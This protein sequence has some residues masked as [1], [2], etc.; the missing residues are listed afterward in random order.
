MKDAKMTIRLPAAELVFAKSY[1]RQHGFSLTAMIHRY[2]AR[3][4]ETARGETPPAI[5]GIAGI[6]PSRVDARKEYHEHR[7]GRSQ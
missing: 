7:L 6:V 5:R 3:L 1:A 4:Q 2:L